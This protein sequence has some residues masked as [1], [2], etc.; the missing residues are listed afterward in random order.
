MTWRSQLSPRIFVPYLIFILFLYLFCLSDFFVWV[1]RIV[2]VCGVGVRSREV[3]PFVHKIFSSSF[4]L[5]DDKGMSPAWPKLD[6][7]H[8]V[9]FKSAVTGQARMDHMVMVKLHSY[10]TFFSTFSTQEN[11]AVNGFK[12]IDIYIKIERIYEL[13]CFCFG[14]HASWYVRP[15][16]TLCV[17]VC[18][19]C[20]FLSLH[21]TW[22]N[23]IQPRTKILLTHDW[24]NSTGQLQ[25]IKRREKMFVWSRYILPVCQSAKESKPSR[26]M[27]GYLPFHSRSLGVSAI[28]GPFPIVHLRVLPSGNWGHKIPIATSSSSVRLHLLKGSSNKFDFSSSE[29]SGTAYSLTGSFSAMLPSLLAWRKTQMSPLPVSTY[30]SKV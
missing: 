30:F 27:P 26:W 20:V 29:S 22:G 21:T 2:C 15:P 13:W 7:R 5:R 12:M 28:S 3:E 11:F 6:Y 1:P 24:V 19:A 17:C 25:P 4:R 10:L 8:P 23:Q 14:V 16:F 9:V 18:F